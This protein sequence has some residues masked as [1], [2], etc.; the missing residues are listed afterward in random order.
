MESKEHLSAIALTMLRPQLTPLQLMEIYHEAGSATSIVEARHHLKEVLPDVSMRIVEV[1]KDLDNA[2]AKAEAEM[3]YAEKHNIKILTP[4]DIDYPQ[5]LKDCPDA[6]LVLYFFGNGDLNPQR[7]VNIIGT[8]KCTSYGKD[9]IR[10]FVSDLKK[11]CPGTLIVSGLAYGVDINAHREALANGL[12]TVG[13][14]AHGLDTIYPAMHR[15]TAKE[16]VSQ[17][18]L[19][20]EYPRNTRP[21]KRNFVQRNRIVAGMSDA[22]ILVESAAK[23]GGLITVGI[24]NSYNRDV[25]AFPG[26][27]NAPYSEGCNKMIRDHQAQLITS[28]DDFVSLMGWEKAELLEKARQQGIERQLFP[29]LNAEETLIVEALQKHGDLQSNHLSVLTNLPIS[30]ISANLFTLEMKGIV[31]PMA[32]GTYHLLS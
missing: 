12:P 15:D 17:G 32:G 21:D 25:F 28:A 7:V 6:P 9:L 8:R 24:S 26:A 31:M 1:M 19:L 10:H 13:V 4:N 27:I 16:M 14:V 5:R 18:G 20:T 22:C 11:M 23:G 2:L 30:T 29:E 3:E